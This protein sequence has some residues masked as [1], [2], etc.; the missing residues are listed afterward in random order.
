MQVKERQN[1]R[2]TVDGQSVTAEELPS[3]LRLAG[4]ISLP[5]TIFTVALLLRLPYLMDVPGFTDEIVEVRIALNVLRGQRPLIDVEP[6][7]GSL[8]NY[9]LAGVFMMLGQHGFVARFFVTLLGAATV[10]L[11]FFLTRQLVG[12]L[13]AFI[14]TGFMATS[15]VHIVTGHIAWTNCTTPFFVTA[16]M[17]ALVE[18][19]ARRSNRLLLLSGLLFGLALQTHPSV[20]FLAP[21]LVLYYLF[22]ARSSLLTP[23]PYLAIVAA[24]TGYVN[25]IAYNLQNPG[26]WIAATH[27]T[28]Y[29]YVYTPTTDSYLANLQ[30][31]AASLVRTISSSFDG[32]PSLE[33]QLVLPF[34]LPYWVLL[35]LGIGCALY[36]RQGLPVLTLVV[37]ALLMPYFNK[38]YSFPIAVRY[39][40]Y[41]LP[42]LYLLMAIPLAQALEKIKRWRRMATILLIVPYLV[43]AILP[44]FN[45]HGYYDRYLRENATSPT[46]LAIQAEIRARYQSNIISKVLLDP[47]LDWVFTAPGGRVLRSFEF[48]MEVEQVPYRTISMAP[49]KVMDELEGMEKP[50]ALILSPA[51]RKRLGERF[52]L[53]E[54]EIP[55]RPYLDRD[56]Y[57]GYILL[58]PKP[59]P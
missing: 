55:A 30:H 54:M 13:A 1:G 40:G 34:N 47:Q 28:D 7:L 15:G 27:R 14:A 21:A 44:L 48:L 45:L 2:R 57:W 26:A 8:F 18:A 43:L 42:V 24:A 41:L 33:A 56:R 31:L 38:D 58:R 4:A 23:W 16:T 10:V 32:D 52:R 49:E 39:L 5:M 22:M 17:L 37:P 25:V 11:T 9:L 29:A 36:R 3:A 53:L 50:V 20:I 12:P 19:V 46:I 51:S 35:F 59:A 6:Y